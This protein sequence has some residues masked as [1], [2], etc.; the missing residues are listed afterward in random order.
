MKFNLDEKISKHFYLKEFFAT[1]ASGGRAGLVRD[2][3]KLPAALQQ[4]YLISLTALAKQLD[5]IRDHFGEALTIESG[6]RSDRV[7]RLVGGA[8]Q[9]FHKKAMA[10]D[11]NVAGHTP[12]QV[13]AWLDMIG[14]KGGVGYGE[15]F[16]HVDIRGY[17]ARWRYGS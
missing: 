10:A 7:N 6:W 13:Q 16:T 12:K 4:K 5:I 15:T 9:S 2:F 14:F 11:F 8:S 1:N 17:K 3:Q